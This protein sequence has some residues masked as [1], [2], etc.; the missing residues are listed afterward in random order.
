LTQYVTSGSTLVLFVLFSAWPIFAFEVLYRLFVKNYKF[1]G[2]FV[3]TSF[4]THFALVAFIPL[5]HDELA[6]QL[7]DSSKLD[8]IILKW[9]LYAVV[10]L[11]C[12]VIECF[13]CIMLMPEKLETENHT[14]VNS[15]T[16]VSKPTSILNPKGS[17]INEHTIID[18]I[19]ARYK[20]VLWGTKSYVEI[21]E[22]VDEINCE[23]TI[24]EKMDSEEAKLWV[25]HLNKMRDKLLDK[26]DSAD[27]YYL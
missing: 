14:H 8:E 12:Y 15:T 19:N 10:I 25:K 21:S 27:N 3:I 9:L 2:I 7:F 17:A 11:I 18:S 1:T 22:K 26:L 4:I 5:R 16:N 24:Y 6:I 13:I 23:I 20:S